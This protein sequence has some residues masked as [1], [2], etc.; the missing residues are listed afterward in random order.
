MLAISGT[1]YSADCTDGDS[2]RDVEDNV[3]KCIG[4]K[5]KTFSKPPAMSLYTPSALGGNDNNS[6]K[7]PGEVC[8][9]GDEK[10][11][12]D[13]YIMKCEKS[14]QTYSW[15]KSNVLKCK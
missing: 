9:I 10:C 1:A 5:W 11:S 8:T 6:H 2:R 12:P 15:N 3:Q 14:Y 13:G 4:G 7:L